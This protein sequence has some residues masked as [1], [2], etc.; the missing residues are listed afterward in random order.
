MISAY[1]EVAYPNIIDIVLSGGYICFTIRQDVYDDTEYGYAKKFQ[2]LVDSRR[3]KE[4][5]NYMTDYIK[6]Y[7]DIQKKCSI[8]CY[9]VLK[10]D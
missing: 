10:N 9:K 8:L 3:W 4:V 5:R 2:E 7:L 6:G 1:C